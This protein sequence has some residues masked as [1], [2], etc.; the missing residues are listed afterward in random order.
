MLNRSYLVPVTY[1]TFVPW[2]EKV[3]LLLK[4]CSQPQTQMGGYIYAHTRTSAAGVVSQPVCAGL[5]RVLWRSDCANPLEGE[6]AKKTQ[7]KYT[8]ADMTAATS[9]GP[10]LWRTLRFHFVRPRKGP[11]GY[12]SHL[13]L[14]L[15]SY[16]GFI[17]AMTPDP[18]SS[19][20]WTQKMLRWV[21]GLPFCCSVIL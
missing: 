15:C 4:C 17:Y 19:W 11:V 14:L 16:W 5:E 10:P 8:G 13:L 12:F 1:S 6:S 20:K 3:P 21:A 9:Q 18:R 2:F 7:F